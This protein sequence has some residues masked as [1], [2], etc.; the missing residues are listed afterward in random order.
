LLIISLNKC[1]LLQENFVMLCP[2]HSSKKLP[3]ERSKSKKK[4]KMQRY[5]IV[6]VIHDSI[7]LYLIVSSD[8]PSLNFADHF[9]TLMI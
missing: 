8:G 3:C 2:T 7:L 5:A 1:D 4:T 9:L 6:P